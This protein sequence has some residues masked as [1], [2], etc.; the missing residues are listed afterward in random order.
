MFAYCNNNPV[1]YA[2]SDGYKPGDLFETMDEAARDAAFYIN[3]QSIAE[4]AEYGAHIYA[5]EETYKEKCYF[6][7]SIFGFDVAIPYY[8]KVTNVYYTYDEPVKGTS[9]SVE[10]GPPDNSMEVVALFHTHAAYSANTNHSNDD[11]STLDIQVTNYNRIPSYLATPN[12]TL[13]LYDPISKTNI[14]V[15]SDIPYDINHPER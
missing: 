14:V 5:I 9:S 7:F 3:E 2:D 15:Y 10:L 4:N 12:G 6:Q 11:F 13:R 1:L 8:K